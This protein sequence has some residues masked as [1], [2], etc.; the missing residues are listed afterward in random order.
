[1]S[2][3]SETKIDLCELNKSKIKGHAFMGKGI[4]ISL[5]RLCYQSNEVTL[6]YWHSSMHQE[7]IDGLHVL[8]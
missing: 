2:N 7:Y 4:R 5:N 8:L 1:M 3:S 6:I